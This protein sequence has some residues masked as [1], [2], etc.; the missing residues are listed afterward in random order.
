MA[1]E[2]TV[3][4]GRHR[5]HYRILQVSSN[6]IKSIGTYSV[7]LTEWLDKLVLPSSDVDA[8]VRRAS[9]ECLPAAV[10]RHWPHYRAST[11]LE[12]PF[13]INDANSTFVG[14]HKEKLTASMEILTVKMPQD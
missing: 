4:K 2:D 5:L 10:Q 3:E 9:D 6:L 8:R 14:E 1:V 11:V 12:V 7:S 13:V